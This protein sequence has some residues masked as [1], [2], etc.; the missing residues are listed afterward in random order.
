MP[1]PKPQNGSREKPWRNADFYVHA[2]ASFF[3]HSAKYPAAE[4]VAIT[5]FSYGEELKRTPLYGAGID[6]EGTLTGESITTVKIV[7]YLEDYENVVKRNIG[8]IRNH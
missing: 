8:T 2:R 1:E 7:M 3:F 5:E 4:A 6:P